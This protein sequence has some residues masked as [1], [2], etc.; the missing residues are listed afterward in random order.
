MK[1]PNLIFKYEWYVLLNYPWLLITIYIHLCILLPT[2]IFISSQ[3]INFTV[4]I[5][6]GSNLKS[7]HF[8]TK[9]HTLLS[10][11]SAE[12]I[13]NWTRTLQQP[14]WPQIKF[15]TTAQCAHLRKVQ[16]VIQDLKHHMIPSFFTNNVRT[17]KLESL[18]S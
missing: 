10:L 7:K 15:S 9:G 14:V 16:R 13:G 11:Q 5:L 17:Q 2:Y 8:C 12:L 3:F 18:I 1:L 4:I 6:E